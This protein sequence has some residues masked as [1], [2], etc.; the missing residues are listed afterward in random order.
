MAEF[1]YSV[2]GYFVQNLIVFSLDGAICGVAYYLF[3]FS[4][5]W[6]LGIVI[7]S[8]YSVA[9]YNMYRVSEIQYWAI[10]TAVAGIAVAELIGRHRL[11]RHA[12]TG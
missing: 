2:V 6:V 12:K 1:V 11:K 5:N 10:I 8:L 7:G 3:R 9:L 4:R